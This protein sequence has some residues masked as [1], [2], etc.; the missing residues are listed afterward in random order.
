MLAAIRS[1]AV[2]GIDAY[3]V[4]VEAD[5]SLGLSSIERTEVL[6]GLTN[7]DQIVISPITGLSEG[8]RVRTKAVDPTTAAN[9]NKTRQEQTFQGFN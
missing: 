4:T 1:A 5:V 8:Q 3:D 6:A 7:D 2:L 9:A